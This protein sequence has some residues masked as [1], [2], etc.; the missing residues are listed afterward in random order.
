MP[1][2]DNI[3]RFRELRGW[4][5]PQLAE[6]MGIDKAGIYKWEDGTTVPGG[7]KLTAIAEALGVSVNDL[8]L[9]NSTSVQNDPAINE[10]P[11]SPR[12]TF[13]QELIEN[14]EDYS[15]IPKAILRDYKIVPER[16][17][18]M[19]TRSK[20]DVSK[21]LEEKHLLIIKGYESQI[22]RLEREKEELAKQKDDL[23]R[24]IPAKNE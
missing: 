4:S 23:Q 1:L 9:E 3:K 6:Q 12:E 17:L 20:D 2:S 18:D 10:K 5:V 13:Y 21:L 8:L 24:Q 7:K 19:I 15:I 22:E 11:M 14:N 16:I